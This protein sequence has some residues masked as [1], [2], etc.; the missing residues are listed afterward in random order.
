MANP[1]AKSTRQENCVDRNNSRTARP[2]AGAFGRTAIQKLKAELEAAVQA[3]L[4]ATESAVTSWINCDSVWRIES[5]GDARAEPDIIRQR[6]EQLCT[7]TGLGSEA[8]PDLQGQPSG[9]RQCATE[10]DGG[11]GAILMLRLKNDDLWMKDC[12]T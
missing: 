2:T 8:R 3:A 9:A 12:A 1:T 7:G 10:N 4:D 6:I 11:T 5:A